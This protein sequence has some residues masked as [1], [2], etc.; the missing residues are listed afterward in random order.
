[1][2]SRIVRPTGAFEL[3][4]PTIQKR[5]RIRD[6]RHL[7]FIASLPSVINGFYGCDAAHIR[8]GNPSWGKRETGGAEKAGD[9]WTVPLTRS[10]H[11]EQHACGDERVYWANV[12]IDPFKVAAALWIHSGDI[13]TCEIIL[14]E[15]RNRG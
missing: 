13:E 6:G 15:A 12:K 14:R 3:G 2:A 1:M 8:M 7:A 11:D 5:P 9:M 10:Q 4:A